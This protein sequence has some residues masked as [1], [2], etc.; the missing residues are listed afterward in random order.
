MSRYIDANELPLLLQNTPCKEL[1]HLY[2]YFYGMAERRAQ[3]VQKYVEESD[4]EAKAEEECRFAQTPLQEKKGT[5]KLPC[6]GIKAC[7]RGRCASG[8]VCGMNQ[9]CILVGRGPWQRDCG[10]KEEATDL[11]P[12]FVDLREATPH[13]C[14]I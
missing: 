3:E 13:A 11:V 2:T 4:L 12:T 7:Q 10:K 5:K 6:F 1:D 8:K 14:R 9:R